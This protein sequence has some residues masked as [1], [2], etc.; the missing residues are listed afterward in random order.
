MLQRDYLIQ[1]E[2]DAFPPNKKEKVIQVKSLR[3]AE[4]WAYSNIGSKTGYTINCI[5][6]KNSIYDAI[7]KSKLISK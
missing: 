7:R 2:D 3:E 6:P 4:E 1:Y 5:R